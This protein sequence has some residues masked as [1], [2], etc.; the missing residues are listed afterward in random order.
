MHSRRDLILG[1]ENSRRHLDGS[2][3]WGVKKRK[4]IVEITIYDE[5]D[6]T[7]PLD[8]LLD[9]GLNLSGIP[10]VSPDWEAVASSGRGK[11]LGS[12]FQALLAT[13]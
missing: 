3:H 12:P 2:G 11:L 13:I 9:S 6:S 4:A 10:N 1:Q 5:I 8:G 7:I